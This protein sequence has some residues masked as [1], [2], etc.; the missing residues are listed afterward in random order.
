GSIL[1]R[2]SNEIFHMSLLLLKNAHIVNDGEIFEGCV[3]INGDRIEAVYAQDAASI[4]ENVE[5]VDF[6]GDYLIPGVIDDQVHFREPGLTYKADIASESAAA[7]AGGITSFME[8][9]NTI[10]QT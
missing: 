7:V 3:L 5:Q 9:P 4:P 6:Q 10:P 1:G 2:A 8:M